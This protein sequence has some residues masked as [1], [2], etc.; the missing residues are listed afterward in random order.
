MICRFFITRPEI[1]SFENVCNGVVEKFFH[2]I[3]KSIFTIQTL[4]L[5]LHPEN[6]MPVRIHPSRA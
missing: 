1:F 3:G 6:N 2:K 5:H 4:L